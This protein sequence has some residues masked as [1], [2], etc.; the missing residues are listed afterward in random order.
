M[1]PWVVEVANRVSPA[2]SSAS[3]L[4]HWQDEIAQLML[5]V[6]LMT[7]FFFFTC[8]NR[9]DIK[10]YE[11]QAEGGDPLGNRWLPQHS[12]QSH[13]IEVCAT[14][15]WMTTLRKITWPK[16]CC[17]AQRMEAGE[18]F[19]GYRDSSRC[20]LVQCTIQ[21]ILFFYFSVLY[22]DLKSKIIFLSV[23]IYSITQHSHRWASLTQNLTS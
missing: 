5:H 8:I 17:G 19:V 2:Q 20:T 1:W 23:A 6:H 10:Y 14:E 11:K 4:K 16:K 3:S 18:R 9:S 22:R 21:F 12:N 13:Y 15:I 7:E